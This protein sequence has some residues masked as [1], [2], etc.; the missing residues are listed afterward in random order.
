MAISTLNHGAACKIHSIHL[1]R[2]TT[3]MA[4]PVT[5]RVVSTTAAV[6][7]S[8][9]LFGT[10]EAMLSSI[11]LKAAETLTSTLPEDERKKLL[12]TFGGVPQ[13]SV[14]N[15]KKVV[16]PPKIAPPSIDE[17]VAKAKASEATRMSAIFEKEKEQLMEEMEKAAMKR[18]ENDLAVQRRQLA[19]EQWKANLKKETEKETEAAQTANTTEKTPEETS[20]PE[21]SSIDSHPILG[22][23]LCD[24]GHKRIHV[25]SAEKLCTIPVWEMQRSYRHDRAKVMANDKK[26]SLHTGLPGIIGVFETSEGKL[27][28]L[29]GQ[30]RVGMLKL[31]LEN[32]SLAEE[33]D[34]SRILVEVYPQPEDGNGDSNAFAKEIFKEIN[35]AQPANMIDLPDEADPA[36]LLAINEASSELMM[37]Y[38]EMFKPSQKCRRPHL[39]VDNLRNDLFLA[40]VVERHNVKTSKDL[41]EWMLEQNKI[42]GQKFQSDEGARSSIPEQALKKAEANNFFLGLDQAWYYH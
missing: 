39:N 38:S 12:E 24:L 9:N 8:S 41:L 13:E 19:F 32:K 11:R 14:P 35:K 7:A 2:R 28:I 3:L 27:F 26:K 31:L 16:E 1:M 18:I 17:L 33:F 42:M 36:V 5:S 20:S 22:E 30:H 21:V 6:H 15:T 40:G 37:T 25:A 23:V 4:W 34:F 29:D 10:A